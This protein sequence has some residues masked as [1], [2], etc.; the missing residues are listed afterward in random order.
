AERDRAAIVVGEVEGVS[1]VSNQLQIDPEAFRNQTPVPDAAIL[2]K[3]AA[4]LKANG[5]LGDVKIASVSDG[6]V[7]LSGRTTTLDKK[8]TAIVAAWTVPGVQRVATEIQVGS[9]RERGKNQ[10][11]KGDER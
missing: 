4:S 1:H 11:T 7:R 6:V 3:V 10:W 2:D 8:L 9:G 5:N